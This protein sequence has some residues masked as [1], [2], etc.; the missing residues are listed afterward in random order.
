MFGTLGSKMIIACLAVFIVHGTTAAAPA[1]PSPRATGTFPWPASLSPPS[2]PD[3]EAAEKAMRAGLALEDDFWATV[4]CVSERI[5][6]DRVD[7]FLAQAR[8][9]RS[10]SRRFLKVSLGEIPAQMRER[11]ATAEHRKGEWVSL[12][13]DTPARAAN[14][15]ISNERPHLGSGSWRGICLPFSRDGHYEVTTETVERLDRGGKFRLSTRAKAILADASQDPD[16]FKWGEMAAHGQTP[17]AKD[18][19]P[20][21]SAAAQERF[22]KFVKDHVKRAKDKC[23]GSE[24]DT[25]EAL[26]WLGFALHA[27][28]DVGSHRGRTNEE[29]AYNAYVENKNPDHEAASFALARDLTERFLRAALSGPLAACRSA[30][31]TYKGRSV[32]YTDKVTRLGLARDLTL[33]ELRRYKASRSAF[34]TIKDEQG[35]RVRWFAAGATPDR[36]SADPGCV[37]LMQALSNP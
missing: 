19:R 5:P 11:A 27:I 12:Y 9:F 33:K 31:A 18:G 2:D 24:A 23:T 29:H 8:A 14:V 36:C 16:I 21:D 4:L 7:A 20:D 22:Q 1:S 25:Q 34:E 3:C 30:F 35:V 6:P 28:Q 17:L 10:S 15:G 26:Y 37:A 32:G 13:V